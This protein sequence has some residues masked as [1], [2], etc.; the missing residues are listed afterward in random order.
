[1]RESDISGEVGRATA[2]RSWCECQWERDKDWCLGGSI[3]KG[4]TLLSTVCKVIGESLSQCWPSTSASCQPCRT[5]G[6]VP[7]VTIKTHPPY[8]KQWLANHCT[9]GN[10]KDSDPWERR[11]KRGV[12]SD[13]PSLLPR[14]FS[15]LPHMEGNLAGVNGD[16]GN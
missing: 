15:L 11:N 5:S 6:N 4:A 10:V 2:F 16:E 13:C 9:S 3:L 14:V 7:L 12:N 1:M 8:M